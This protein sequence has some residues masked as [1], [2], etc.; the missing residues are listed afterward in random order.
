MTRRSR[1]AVLA[2]AIA[3]I[4]I[5]AGTWW[6]TT[7]AQVETAEAHEEHAEVYYCPMH[8]TVQSDKP[9]S[10]PICGMAL[11]KRTA[12]PQQDAARQLQQEGFAGDEIAAISLSPE[13]RVTA[14][15]RTTT[16]RMETASADL[17]TTGRI[18]ID[19][20][21]VAQIT[22]YSGGRIERLD[23]NFTGDM[24]RR[25]Q[26][27]AAIYSPELYSSQQEYLL[28]LRNR[29]RMREAGFDGARGASEDLVESGRRRLLLMGMT[30][31]QI[32]QL[33]AGGQPLYTT[34]V[35][36]PVSGVVIRKLVVPQQYVTTG[37]P[38]F[39]VADLSHVWVD[40]NVYEQQL[41]QVH[42]GQRVQITSPAFAGQTLEGTVE[43]IQPT[44]AGEARTASVR[45]DL[46]NPS[47]LL[48]PDMYVTVRL[49]GGAVG[50]HIMVPAGA[51]IDRGQSRFVWVETTPGTYEP[52]KVSTGPRHGEQIVVTDGLRAGDV[53]VTEGGFLLDSEAQLR[54]ITSGHGAH[55]Q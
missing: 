21:R 3:V 38:L 54:N 31:R 43:F 24:I 20:R 47:Q 35:V 22:A 15:V 23:V 44:I 46:P 1:L 8:P 34:A 33:E 45:I 29:A 51:V 2:L 16:V 9:G 7:R 48:K 50:E 26:V 55:P 5:A 6:W 32:A 28:A 41:S 12:A 17:L 13:Q 39:D 53:I 25:G 49:I 27:V 37:Q 52:R 36:S 18:T 10:C 11:V 30:E 19:E 14:N 42:Q 40:A 4:A